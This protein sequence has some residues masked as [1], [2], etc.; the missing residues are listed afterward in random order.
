MLLA[1]S[2]RGLVF[3]FK[4]KPVDGKANI[5]KRAFWITIENVLHEVAGVIIEDDV[6]KEMRGTGHSL[7]QEILLVTLAIT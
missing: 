3:G 7:D 4:M 6:G 1:E 2:V 5:S